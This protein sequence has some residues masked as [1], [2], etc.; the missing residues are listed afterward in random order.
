MMAGHHSKLQVVIVTALIISLVSLEVHSQTTFPYITLKG[1]I[2]RNNSWIE[3]STLL[4]DDKLQCV[5]DSDSCCEDMAAESA[6]ILPNGT[7]LSKDGVR[8]I[9]SFI[10]EA[11][12][13][14]LG[15][16]LAEE[17]NTAL[18][19]VYECSIATRTAASESVYVGIY[20]SPD[21]GEILSFH[22]VSL[23][24]HNYNG[25]FCA[26]YVTWY[27]VNCP[28]EEDYAVIDTSSGPSPHRFL[29]WLYSNTV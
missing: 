13:Q 4:E 23:V 3:V 10:V 27:I 18:P 5:T 17:R 1:K 25:H 24:L 22:R 19:G 21:V 2:L 8:E 9:S 20:H 29:A 28:Y 14:Q 6:W 12:P 7:E 26:I 15:L 16:K 11:G